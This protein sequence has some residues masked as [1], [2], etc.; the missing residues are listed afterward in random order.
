M[1]LWGQRA[2]QFSAR[3]VYDMNEAKPVVVLFLG[4]LM[5]HYFGTSPT[6]TISIFLH[7]LWKLTI[8]IDKCSLHLLFSST[9]QDQLSGSH[10]CKWYFNPEIPEADD[11]NTR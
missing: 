3:K 11:L 4:C 8:S 7:G 9:A 10:A 2:I 5:K 6:T 1:T